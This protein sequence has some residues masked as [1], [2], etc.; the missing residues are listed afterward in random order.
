MYNYLLLFIILL[1]S[2]LCDFCFS[3]FG[4]SEMGFKCECG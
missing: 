1:A 4:N 2:A 3:I